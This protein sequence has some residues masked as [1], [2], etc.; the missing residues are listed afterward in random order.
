MTI[1]QHEV[2]V[3]EFARAM[4]EEDSAFANRVQHFEE[5]FGTI[6]TDVLAVLSQSTYFCWFEHEYE[7]N[8]VAVCQAIDIGKPTSFFLCFQITS[9]RWAEIN[10]YV[11]GVQRWLGW[12]KNS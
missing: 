4:V 10:T 8:L 9:D 6:N 1:V 7:S 12:H 3:K 11:V 5:R 2:S